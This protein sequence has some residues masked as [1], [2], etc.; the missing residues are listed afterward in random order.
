MSAVV[1]YGR[2][3]GAQGVEICDEGVPLAQDGLGGE[4]GL[5]QEV[6]DDPRSKLRLDQVEDAAALGDEVAGVEGP[7][8]VGPQEAPV[9]FPRIASPTS[10]GSR[11][12]FLTMRGVNCSWTWLNTAPDSAPGARTK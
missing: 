4:R 7:Q 3:L 12:K 1:V 8:V 10:G 2:H 11:S 6:R 9:L 5:A